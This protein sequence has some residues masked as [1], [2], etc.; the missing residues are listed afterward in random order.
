MVGKLVTKELLFQLLK[1]SGMKV[2]AK[3]AGKFVPVAGQLA[4]A[5][6]GFAM[7][8]KLGYEHVEACA[9]VARTLAKAG[10]GPGA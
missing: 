5:A 9:K 8:R 6:I 4:S 1:R 2:L 10:K 7:F 3:S